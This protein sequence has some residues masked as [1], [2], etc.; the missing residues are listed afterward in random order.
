MRDW[1]L[2][3]PIRDFDLEVFGVDYNQLAEALKPWGKTDL[4]G[5]SFG[6][7]KLNTGSGIYD[8]SI[9][10]SD[11][12]VAPGHKGF[13]MDFD[14]T[15]TP[16]QASARR[17]F[18]MNSLMFDPRQGEILDFHGGRQ[19][20]KDRV[21]RHTSPAFVEDPL[22]VLRGMQLISRFELNP[23]PET[24]ELCRSIKNAFH[25]LARERVR[26]EWFKWA[27]QSDKPSS[28]LRFLKATGWLEHFPQIL[29]MATTPQDPEWHPEGD[30]FI[31]T[32]HCCDA[33]AKLPEWRESDLESRIVYMMAALA[34]DFGKAITTQET[35]RS[36]RMRII[37]PGHEIAGCE[38]AESFLNEML[39]PR[40]IMD[41]VLPLIENHLFHIHSTITDRSVR[42]LA[43]RL[44]PET[45]NG[46][47]ILMTADHFARP[48][49]PAVI[50][51]SIG[52]LRDKARSMSLQ[53]AAPKPLLQGRHLIELGMT[54]G[55]VFAVIL[56]A[57]FEAQ[58][59]GDF[60]DLAGAF[61]WMDRGSALPLTPEARQNL[62]SRF[63]QP[64][65]SPV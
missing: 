39:S 40:R 4:V 44:E 8:F 5:Q 43:R 45:M 64:S 50:P 28:G 47:C 56:K 61:H 59:D 3:R 36:G 55:P 42:R 41:R 20:L 30:V 52:L 23:A 60:E 29:A 21:L 1:L 12:K 35:S 6:V 11:S 24:L 27:G 18:T 65:T 32:C 7:I 17:D 48:P 15:L 49:K 38:L 34:H 63:D 57:A 10:R 37:S 9:P 53:S 25:E 51:E 54:P 19:D 31:H 14:R 16:N 22:R 58:L 62:K 33:M 13:E 26:D 2:N 46:L